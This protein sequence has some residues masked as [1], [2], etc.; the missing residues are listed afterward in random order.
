MCIQFRFSSSH[1]R[2]VQIDFH[3]MFNP[4]Y[5]KCD[6]INTFLPCYFTVFFSY[7]IFNSHVPPPTPCLNHHPQAAHFNLDTHVSGGWWVLHGTGTHRV[8]FTTSASGQPVDPAV[9]SK[10]RFGFNP[11]IERAFSKAPSDL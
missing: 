6:Y 8:R 9:N 3:G 10:C 2:K 7:Y 4:I 11:S 5:P 1:I